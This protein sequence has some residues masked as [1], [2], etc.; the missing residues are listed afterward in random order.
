[1]ISFKKCYPL[2]YFGNINT[3]SLC[4]S[5]VALTQIYFFRH[6][7]EKEAYIKGAVLILS[8][9]QTRTKYSRIFLGS[10]ND[11]QLLPY[12]LW[13]PFNMV[14]ILQNI[15]LYLLF[16]SNHLVSGI[17][18]SSNKTIIYVISLTRFHQMRFFVSFAEFVLSGKVL[19]SFKFKKFPLG[20]SSRP[21]SVGEEVKFEIFYSTYCF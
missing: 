19:D 20:I 18:F 3:I 10:I 12:F 9:G 4:H 11:S 7:T 6:L 17:I 5:C 1:M 16:Y 14:S 8:R 21:K 15:S 2:V 13:L